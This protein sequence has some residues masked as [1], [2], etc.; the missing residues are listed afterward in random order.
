MKKEIAWRISYFSKKIRKIDWNI[1]REMS[2]D[3]ATKYCMQEE[4]ML[5]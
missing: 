4:N 1:I 5:K 3:S 2:N